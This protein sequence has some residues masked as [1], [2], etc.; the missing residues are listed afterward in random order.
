MSEHWWPTL[1]MQPGQNKLTLSGSRLSHSIWVR[2]CSVALQPH[3]F[4]HGSEDQKEL[5]ELVFWEDMALIRDRSRSIKWEEL[6]ELVFWEDMALIRDRSRSIKWE[7]LSE[8]V[9]L[10]RE[11]SKSIK[12]L[13]QNV[14]QNKKIC[15]Q[16]ILSVT[17][18][19]ILFNHK[20]I[21]GANTE[22]LRCMRNHQNC[23][24]FIT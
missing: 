23:M 5:S 14:V 10:T 22:S 20:C 17:V 8:F 21:M 1:V 13:L 6:S 18:K 11:R 16:L 9:F 3:I 24:Y 19:D 4:T 7:K 12:R 15:T 2:L